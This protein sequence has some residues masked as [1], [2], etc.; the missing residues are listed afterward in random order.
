MLPYPHT[1]V[2][3]AAGAA[4]GAVSLTATNL[5]DLESAAPAEFGGPGDQ[6]SPE[7]L[8]CAAVADC[9]VLTFRAMARASKFEW[10]DISCRTEGILDRVDGVARFSRFTTSVTL[11]V[12][13]GVD[14]VKAQQL[15]ERSERGCL[16]A[17]SLSAE[18]SLVVDV[19][20]G[21]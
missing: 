14:I 10:Q 20:V 16:I 2:V 6:W 9:L 19:L 18:R 12:M 11:K 13:A 3:N 8:V 17:N 5:P 1:Y 4:S 7:T 15:L 21:S